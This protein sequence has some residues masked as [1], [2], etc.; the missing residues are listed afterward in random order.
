MFLAARND[1]KSVDVV[2]FKPS[3][4]GEMWGPDLLFP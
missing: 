2:R 3:V 4:G 1:K